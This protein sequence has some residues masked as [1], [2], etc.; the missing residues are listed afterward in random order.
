M[1]SYNAHERRVRSDTVQFLEGYIQ[2]RCHYS[3]FVILGDRTDRAGWAAN[4]AG[5]LVHG[6]LE[7]LG[8]AWFSHRAEDAQKEAR[9]W[10]DVR[11]KIAALRTLAEEPGNHTVSWIAADTFVDPAFARKRMPFVRMNTLLD[12]DPPPAT[13]SLSRLCAA[14]F[15]LQRTH[16]PSA[17]TPVMMRDELAVVER[18]RA[19][20]A[21]RRRDD[22]K[23][24]IRREAR[25]APSAALTRFVHDPGNTAWQALQVFAFRPRSRFHRTVR[26]RAPDRSLVRAAGRRRRSEAARKVARAADYHLR[27]VPEDMHGYRSLRTDLIRLVREPGVPDRRL[28]QFLER[29]M[30]RAG[31]TLEEYAAFL[32][33]LPGV[34][35]LLPGLPSSL[36][37]GDLLNA[38]RTRTL[39]DIGRRLAVLRE[40]DPEIREQALEQRP[41]S[42]AA[43]AKAVAA[44]EHAGF[45]DRIAAL[46]QKHWPDADPGHLARCAAH[47]GVWRGIEYLLETMVGRVAPQTL[48]AR[49]TWRVSPGDAGSHPLDVTFTNLKVPDGWFAMA[50]PAI[51]VDFAGFHHYAHFGC[52]GGYICVHQGPE[53]LPVMGG[54]LVTAGDAVLLNNL[55]GGL[56]RGANTAR[57]RQ[58]LANGV[59]NVLGRV[60]RPVV[61]QDLGF[62]ALSLPN[63]LGL[64]AR[65]MQL[66]LPEIRLDLK[67][68]DQASASS[69]SSTP[70]REEA[71]MG[72]QIVITEKGSQAR[73]V[74]AAVGTR[75]GRVLAAEG[76]LLELVEPADVN[77]E[78]K[79]WSTELLMPPGG[80]YPLTPAA[81]TNRRRK[82]KAI[83]E[84]LR[85]AERVWIA[86]D[87]DREGQLIGQEILEFCHFRGAVMRVLFVAQDPETIREA[88]AA[89]RPN[90]EQANLYAAAVARRQVDQICNLSLTRAATVTLRPNGRG[91]IG[92]GRVRTPTLGIVCRR[93]LEIRAFRPVSYWRIAARCVAA[94]GGRFTLWHDP[95][96]RILDKGDAFTLAARVTGMEGPLSVEATRKRRRP[97]GLFDLPSLQQACNRRFGWTSARTLELAQSLYDGE[98][99]KILTYPRAETRYLPESA[100]GDFLEMIVGLR[101]AGVAAWSGAAVPEPPVIRTGKAGSFWDAGLA[102]CSHHA[103]IPNVRTIGELPSILARLSED[104]RQLFDLVARACLAAV[105]E[106]HEFLQTDVVL[107]LDGREFKATG[108]QTQEPGWT[109]VLPPV[110]RGKENDADAQALPSLGNGELARV[111]EAEAE[112]RATR[113]PPR[114]SEGALIAAMQNAWRFVDEGPLRA[115]L[116]EAKGIGTAATRDGIIA[117]LRKQRLLTDKGRNLV[118]TEAGLELHR[119]LEAADPS[120]GDPVLTAELE[121]LLD[122]VATGVESMDR[123]METICSAAGASIRRLV[124]KSGSVSTGALAAGEKNP[125]SGKTGRSRSRGGGAAR[126]PTTK[127]IAFAKDLAKRKSVD[128]PEGWDSDSSV[129]RAFLDEHAGPR[130][131]QS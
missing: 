90:S 67:P 52:D 44:I 26:V 35:P 73:D 15:R 114:Y 99:R 25:T 22:E 17:I 28:T 70:Q 118:P 10:H 91:V 14:W 125:G 3:W 39:H 88:F 111:T 41:R 49:I 7:L 16:A 20:Y 104:E 68:A 129:C 50:L 109:A 97:P 124:A 107:E 42:L 18:L 63:E 85:R 58:R 36:Y 80:L 56:T 130:R 4:Q 12:L 47:L 62:N 126:A 93:E 43:A 38:L 119:V 105:M 103:L 21:K 81:A 13:H 100:K 83:R 128:L 82:L 37:A 6:H 92:V 72:S 102:G 74:S 115:R 84:A 110:S 45:A 66:E 61:M 113:P 59:R 116:Q 76:H 24:A 48:P 79:R 112:P 71:I 87:A 54:F 121:C 46:V 117:G 2:H 108:R 57:R 95:E 101:R 55:Q 8:E 23:R 131:R 64:P 32:H 19:N 5:L 30:P 65:H 40:A 94:S 69:S 33:D 53:R 27:L 75:Y 96:E 98:G 1:S 77:P 11:C 29:L 86:T 123:V 31:E 78:W 9:W 106:D 51:C 122:S 127:M 60:G 34:L 120:L 89:A